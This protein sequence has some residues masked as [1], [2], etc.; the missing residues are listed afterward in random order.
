MSVLVIAKFGGSSMADA[1]GFR[2][3]RAPISS[4]GAGAVYVVLSAPGTPPLTWTTR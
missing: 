3:V 2:R 4:P 1:D